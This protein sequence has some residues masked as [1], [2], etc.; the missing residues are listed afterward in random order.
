[1][2]RLL[3]GGPLYTR[4]AQ[5][6]AGG[7]SLACDVYATFEAPFVLS[8]LLTQVSPSVLFPA[9]PFPLAWDPKLGPRAPVTWPLY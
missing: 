2:W 7:R 8:F 5:G 6:G 1:M 4:Q 3:G 9:C